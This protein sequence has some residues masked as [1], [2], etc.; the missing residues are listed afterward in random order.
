MRS[1]RSE[2]P[3]QHEI[4]RRQDFALGLGKEI[5]DLIGQSSKLGEVV[6]LFLWHG[7]LPLGTGGKR[8][9]VDYAF[10][11]MSPTASDLLDS[12]ET[13]SEEV[14]KALPRIT[15]RR[16]LHYDAMWMFEA[17]THWDPVDPTLPHIGVHLY[18]CEALYE[19]AGDSGWRKDHRPAASPLHLL[20]SWRRYCFFY[21]HWIYEGV[22]LYDPNCLFQEIQ[23]KGFS[24]PTWL[25]SDLSDMV[26]CVAKSYLAD[27]K[28]SCTVDD[29]RDLALSLFALLAYGIEGKPIGRATRYASDC[30]EFKSRLARA[31]L[32]AVCMANLHEAAQ[33]ILDA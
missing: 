18:R 7:S 29:S 10:F 22:P 31:I 33:L 19:L 30:E 13:V 9:D 3:Q 25:L 14:V 27:S 2:V 11:L 4:E 23:N 15:W 1:G 28:G 21:R 16:D 8:Y 24:P 20:D 32:S 12:G 17:H 5:G 6:T 26:R